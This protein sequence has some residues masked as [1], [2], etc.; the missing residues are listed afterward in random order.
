ME[1]G[2]GVAD[3][4]NMSLGG[5]EF[6]ALCGLRG[7]DDLVE[8]YLVVAVS[9]LTN[10]KRRCDA[11]CRVQM[12]GDCRV[13]QLV[14]HGHGVHIA[15]DGFTVQHDHSFGRVN[16]DDATANRVGLLVAYGCCW[17]W[18]GMVRAFAAC[19]ERR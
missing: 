5:L 12:D 3:G 4:G 8:Q 17:R 9:S 14:G 13:L 18:R 2:H 1:V 11:I 15:G 16:A 10:Q 6:G 19:D 7:D